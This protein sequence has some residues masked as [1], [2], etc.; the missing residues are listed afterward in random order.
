MEQAVLILVVVVVVAKV[1]AT[2]EA[3]AALEL[4]LFD[5]LKQLLQLRALQ[6]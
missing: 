6:L 2:L 4:L 5:C 3:Q 1:E